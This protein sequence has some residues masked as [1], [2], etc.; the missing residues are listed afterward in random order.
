M[1]LTQHILDKIEELRLQYPNATSIG[2]GKKQSNGVETGEFAI[3]VG[4]KEKK[5]TSLIPANELLPVEVIVSNQSL[6]TDVVEVYENFVLGTCSSSCGNINPGTNNAANRATVRPIQGGTSM[7]SRNN[8][9]TVGTLGGIVRHTDS[10]CTVG[11]T[12][13]HVSISDAFFTTARDSNGILENDYDPVNRV[14]QNGEQGSS[15]PTSLNFGVSL[16]YVPIHPLSTGLVNQVDA[17][18]F[19]IDESAFSIS[20]SW[21]QVGLESIL[22]NNAPPFASTTELDNL[23]ATNPRVYSSG[24]TTGAKGFTPD[25]PMTIHQTGVTINLEYKLQGVGTLCQF[26]RSISFIKPTQEEPNAQKP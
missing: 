17:A 4:V 10:G 13:N 18:I 5:D 19:S 9:T 16:R 14:Y 3:I 23:L 11:L 22:G 8:N 21:N 15:T 24:R 25:C 20:Q 6:K 7:S 1:R 2:F 26:S 12:N